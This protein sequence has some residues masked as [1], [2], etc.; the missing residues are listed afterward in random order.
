MKAAMAGIIGGDGAQVEEIPGRLGLE[1]S[2]GN[3]R[4]DTG[5]GES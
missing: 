2:V 4:R 1:I 5:H 3:R